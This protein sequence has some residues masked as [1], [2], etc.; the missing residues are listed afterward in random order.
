LQT[1]HATKTFSKKTLMTTNANQN[2]GL[3]GFSS[4]ALYEDL[5][6]T[7]NQQVQQNFTNTQHLTYHN[8]GSK[9]ILKN[10]LWTT[11]TIRWFWNNTSKQHI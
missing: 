1:T 10:H 4:L 8:K 6:N 7:K 11:P 5:Q 9:F 2:W 3:Q